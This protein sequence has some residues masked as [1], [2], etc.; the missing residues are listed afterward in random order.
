M[1]VLNRIRFIFASNDDIHESLDEF[2]IWPDP[3]T[4]FHGN[5]W[6]I[7]EK[8]WCHFFL[9]VL[10]R[11]RFILASND[12][13]HESL[14]EFEIW[15]D[16]ITGFHSNRWVIMEKT[17]LPLFLGCFLSDPFHTCR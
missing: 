2:E 6:V 5:I 14:D 7:M 15:P 1:A 9:A 8:W 16:P 12:G 13:I 11:I 4:D 17:V 3:T 10:D